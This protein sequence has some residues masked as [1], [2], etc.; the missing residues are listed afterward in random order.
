M[1]RSFLTVVDIKKLT[2]VDVVY[3]LINMEVLYENLVSFCIIC[4]NTWPLSEDPN[5]ECPYCKTNVNTAK[6]LDK[7]QI[8]W[9]L[10]DF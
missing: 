2:R 10:V 4:D 5:D 6:G 1:N 7:V 3:S 8:D 9:L